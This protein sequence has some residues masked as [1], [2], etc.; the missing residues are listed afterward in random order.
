MVG[1]QTSKDLQQEASLVIDQLTR[2]FNF[3]R[4]ST[5]TSYKELSYDKRPCIFFDID[6]TLSRNDNLVLLINRLSEKGY[7]S[8][9][10]VTQFLKVR[11]LWKTRT[12]SFD[13]YAKVAI[14]YIRYLK[15]IPR[16]FLYRIAREVIKD[17]GSFYYVFTYNL[18]ISLHKFGYRLC[19]VTGSPDFMARFFLKSIKIPYDE[20]HATK[21]IF[22]K[23]IFTGNVD[24]S[25]VKNKGQFLTSNFSQ[26][27]LNS[28]IALGDTGADAS[29]FKVVRYKIAINPTLELAQLAYKNMWPIA[30][31]R[32]NLMLLFLDGDIDEAVPMKDLV[33]KE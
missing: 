18:L 23:G 10:K 32:K 14:E 21:Y 7:F 20:I 30:I 16:D 24:A 2:L 31:E 8:R 29:M 5:K 19:A 17:E 4:L 27:I 11:R 15:N 22:Q 33:I 25:I 1:S 28:S 26:D 13:L 12:W 6:G 3:W 9:R